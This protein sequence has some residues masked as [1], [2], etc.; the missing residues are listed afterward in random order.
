M[1]SDKPLPI[2][3]YDVWAEEPDIENGLDSVSLMHDRSPCG[4][5]C[6]ADDV[7]GLVERMQMDV[8]RGRDAVDVCRCLVRAFLAHDVHNGLTQTGAVH[9]ETMAELFE[10]A[11]EALADIEKDNA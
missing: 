4:D 5:W 11:Q 9:K 1:P 3:T 8:D 10:M 6:K 7:R 2:P